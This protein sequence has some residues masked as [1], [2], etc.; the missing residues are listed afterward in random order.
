MTKHTIHPMLARTTRR[1]ALMFGVAL[2]ASMSAVANADQI[3]QDGTR[4]AA[5]D[6]AATT[7]SSLRINTAGSG[8][9]VA[10]VASAANDA[11]APWF[12]DPQARLAASG[13]F[14]AVD[15]INANTV[16]PTP[17]ELANYDAVL[18]WS[19]LSF[20]DEVALGDNLAEY[21]DSGGGVVLA[22]FANSS[23][24]AEDGPAG[25]WESHVYQIVTPHAGTTA[26]AATLGTVH[27]PGHP[28]MAG[29]TSFDGGSSSFR[30]TSTDL[31][32]SAELIAE[33][34]DGKV[35]AAVREDTVG[36]RVDLGFY[37]PSDAVMPGF[38][39]ATTDGDLL[40]VNALLYAATRTPLAPGDSNGDG[41]VDLDDYTKFAACQT[42]ADVG[43]VTAGCVTFDFDRDDDVDCA[44]WLALSDVWTD[45]GSPPFP[46]LCI[47]VVPA[48]SDWGL[49]VLA[50][51]LVTAGS[52]LMPPTHR[53]RPVAFAVPTK[54]QPID[55]PPLPR[56]R[57]PLHD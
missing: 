49:A 44:D 12:T 53:R 54:A 17:T 21:V 27:D 31:V 34:S 23:P 41:N 35:L 47:G 3:A 8:P 33:W 30:P 36:A 11:S 20:A 9:A 40:L 56:R 10:I 4:F 55:M 46:D 39:D 42:G 29:V 32:P 16:T 45:A 50:L 26:G 18:V 7:R 19:N 57:G 13:A 37:P 28:I 48:A 43:P 38:W 25:R 52:L 6:P 15:I 5:P 51:F 2:V 1:L 22:V 14:S 24:D